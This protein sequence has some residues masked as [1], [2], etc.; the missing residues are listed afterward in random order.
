MGL[1]GKARNVSRQMA[2]R[3]KRRVE[4]AAG[5]LRAAADGTK[6]RGADPRDAERP[7]HGSTR[8]TDEEPGR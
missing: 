2:G 6:E 4:D 1:M 3:T 7:A 5:N 8:S